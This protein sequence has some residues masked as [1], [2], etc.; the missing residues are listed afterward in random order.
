MGHQQEGVRGEEIRSPFYEVTE[1]SSV[2]IGER[3]S[4]G[5]G[6]RNPKKVSEDEMLHYH[7]NEFFIYVIKG[8][9]RVVVGDQE[10]NLGPGWLAYIPPYTLHF[11]N[12]IEDGTQVLKIKDTISWGHEGIPKDKKPWEILREYGG[13][14]PLGSM[15]GGAPTPIFLKPSRGKKIR[16]QE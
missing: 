13:Y 11:S 9:L 6:A 12:P 4:V 1:K 14:N 5:C 3:M 16:E 10:K 15:P 7:P 2:I 8:R